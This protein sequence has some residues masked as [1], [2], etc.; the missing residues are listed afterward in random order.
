MRSTS[1]TASFDQ[2]HGLGGHTLRKA[3]LLPLF[4]TIVSG[5]SSLNE[6]LTSQKMSQVVS[7][8][9]VIWIV[10]QAVSII[11]NI[12]TSIRGPAYFLK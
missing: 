6:N 3:A 12:P 10:S 9:S 7:V 2:E 5:E 4:C 8:V 1:F 11:L